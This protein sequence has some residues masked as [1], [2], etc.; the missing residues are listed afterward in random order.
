MTWLSFVL[1]SLAVFRITRLIVYDK[2]TEFL[3]SPFMMEVEEKDEDGNLEVYI[4]PRET[5]LRGWF[6]Q[7]LS[8]YWCTG[9][10][11]SILIITLKYFFPVVADIVIFIFAV[12]GAAAFIE[13]VIQRIGIL[14]E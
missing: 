6:G 5:G 13:T 4:V 9:I 1:V 12:A 11:V 14:G 8:C 10:W 3:R 7:L 2:I